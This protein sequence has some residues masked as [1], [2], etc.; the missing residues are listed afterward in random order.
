[1]PSDLPQSRRHF[2]GDL[3]TGFG[4]IALAAMLARDG[5]QPSTSLG[6]ESEHPWWYP[7]NG[8]PHHAPKVKSVIWLFMAGG[9]SHVEGFDPKPELNKYGGKTIKET[10]YD[11]LN[12]PLI[13]NR[14]ELAKNNANGRIYETLYPMQVGYRQHGQSG[15]AV[16]D[17][18]P[19]VAGCVDDMAFV[20]SMWTTASDHDA[21]LQFH[22][23]RNR[24]DG[25][26][27]TIGAWV[28]YGLG[29]LN[30]R[31]PQFIVMGNKIGDCCGGKAYRGFGLPGPGT[32]W[33]HAL[34]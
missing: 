26:F 15:I 7:P 19:H 4:G 29:S 25:F 17:W 13:A 31:L 20:R 22:T 8:K 21:Q 28:H 5:F 2:L 3:G 27:P 6:A 33:R 30:D 12:S 1:M 10:P 18:W 24:F 16:S 23:G 34:G 11:P 32:S 9:V 14:V